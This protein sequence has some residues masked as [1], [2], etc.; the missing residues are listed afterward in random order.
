MWHSFSGFQKGLALLPSSNGSEVI[1]VLM[2]VTRIQAIMCDWD[3]EKNSWVEWTKILT[4]PLI[5]GATYG[6]LKPIF[7]LIYGIQYILK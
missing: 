5:D 1:T 2:R 7:C 6:L 4:S 3:P